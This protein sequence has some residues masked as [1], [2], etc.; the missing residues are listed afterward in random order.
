MH[1]TPETYTI[2][3]EAMRDLSSSISPAVAAAF[4]WSRYPVIADIGVTR[5]TNQ[6]RPRGILRMDGLCRQRTSFPECG[7]RVMLPHA[8][9]SSAIPIASEVRVMHSN[10][11]IIE[12]LYEA[13]ARG[14]AGA[15]LGVFHP[16]IVWNEAEN[17][18]YADQNPYVGPQRVGEG[19]FGRIMSEW[20][21]FSVNPEKL[22]QENDTVV[23]LGRYRGAYRATGQ[24]LDAQ[25]VHVWT[26]EKGQITRFQQYAD[27]LEFARVTGALA[28]VPALPA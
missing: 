21:G 22:I 20:D 19:V 25:F 6:A 16:E 7:L 8:G 13:F 18:P 14:D 17:F 5:A 23:A 3:N 27:T 15:V 9:C 10:R 11:Q 4:D 24:P 2:F 12:S 26:I 1:S 28:T